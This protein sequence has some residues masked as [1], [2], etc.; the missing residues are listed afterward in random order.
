MPSVLC[1]AWK[2]TVRGNRCVSEC[3]SECDRGKAARVL[4]D[5]LVCKYV[6]IKF[7]IMYYILM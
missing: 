2:K 7:L 1:T 3:V 4:F 5:S 6:F